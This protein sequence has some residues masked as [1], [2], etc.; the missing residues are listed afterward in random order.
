MPHTGTF[1]LCDEHEELAR[2][3]RQRWHVPLRQVPKLDV[4]EEPDD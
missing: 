3:L 4:P 1:L 2:H